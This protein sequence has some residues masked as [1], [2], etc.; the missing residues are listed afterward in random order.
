V[1]FTKYS[2]KHAIIWQNISVY[3][4]QENSLLCE[5]M[6]REDAQIMIIIIKS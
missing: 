6:R 1:A 2:K 3:I 4:T 5:L